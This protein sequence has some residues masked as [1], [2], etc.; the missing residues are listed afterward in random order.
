MFT[1]QNPRMQF[2][3]T[4]KRRRTNAVQA[5]KLTKHLRVMGLLLQTV[6]YLTRYSP[7]C[8]TSTQLHCGRSENAA[9]EQPER[10]HNERWVDTG[11]R[12]WLYTWCQP[13]W[14]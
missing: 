1:D 7:V 8:G 13:S 9:R 11:A 5:E 6:P 4:N 14:W 3:S 10:Q 12:L 2:A